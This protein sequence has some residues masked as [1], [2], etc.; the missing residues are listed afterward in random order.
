MMP[1]NLDRRAD[2]STC[3]GDYHIMKSECQSAGS[4]SRF[5]AA[6]VRTGEADPATIR[7]RVLDLQYEPS[8]RA[9]Q[10]I[11][12]PQTCDIWQNRP[13]MSTLFCYLCAF[14]VNS[15]VNLSPFY[16]FS[17]TFRLRTSKKEFFLVWGPEKVTF[18]LF[19]D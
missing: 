17:Y 18:G 9:K 15:P 14:S 10:G 19:E 8:L 3:K 5:C 6:T 4:F 1:E 2:F 12:S 13:Q 11:F 16:L 7:H